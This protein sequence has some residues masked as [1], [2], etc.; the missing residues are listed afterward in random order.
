M[1]QLPTRFLLFCATVLS[2]RA[3]LAGDSLLGPGARL[4]S[5]KST[6]PYEPPR[7]VIKLV[8]EPVTEPR[9]LIRHGI[10]EATV[11]EFDVDKEQAGNRDDNQARHR[12]GA[13]PLNRTIVRR[14]ELT[15]D[16]C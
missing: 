10:D 1:R 8:V 6:K 13:D 9:G 4:T 12:H 5:H 3:K 16:N 15:I 11:A 14:I 7:Q 2:L